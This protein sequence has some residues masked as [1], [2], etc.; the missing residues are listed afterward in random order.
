M[1]R[2]SQSGTAATAAAAPPAK[3]PQPLP[4]VTFRRPDQE[5]AFDPDK[6][7][8]RRTQATLL[9]NELFM[10][11]LRHI[12]AG[13]N[14][15]LALAIVLGE[16]GHRQVGHLFANPR[17]V[18]KEME[19]ELHEARQWDHRF[20]YTNAYSISE[21][22][23]IPRETVR[24]KVAQL[25]AMGLVQKS[26]EGAL[27]CTPGVIDKFDGGYNQELMHRLLATAEQLRALVGK[28][29]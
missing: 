17:G 3:S 1:A 18:T 2:L 7:R 26:A 15:D 14:G 22:T 8:E 4:A 27:T 21:A 24:R 23:G 12:Y 29:P 13:F 9:M 25:I 19:R 11:H 10:W 5:L 28:D 16:I 6:Y 20:R